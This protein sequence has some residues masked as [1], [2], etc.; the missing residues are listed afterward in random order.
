[1]DGWLGPGIEP[2]E[3]ERRTILSRLTSC[4]V[5]T[6][7]PDGALE[8]RTAVIDEVCDKGH[9]IRVRLIGRG[10][11]DHV[12]PNPRVVVS[13]LPA[14]GPY[15]LI[16]VNGLARIHSHQAAR[17]GVQLLVLEV[18]VQ[19]MECWR[20]GSASAAPTTPS[21]PGFREIDIPDSRHD[22]LARRRA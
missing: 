16:A 14:L 19:R 2:A 7:S 9:S 1:M 18:T 15:A 21:T 3:T 20:G 10:L 13:A 8:T 4:S 22:A 5:T 6:S 17:S 12:I 11:Y